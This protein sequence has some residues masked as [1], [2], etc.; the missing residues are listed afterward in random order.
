MDEKNQTPNITFANTR[1]QTLRFGG[2]GVQHSACYRVEYFVHLLYPSEKNEFV[3]WDDFSQY[4][5]K[6]K[7]DP[8]HQPVYPY[9]TD[10]RKIIPSFLLL[11]GLPY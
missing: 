2:A 11:L 3:S 5:Q 6:N 10:G 9:I 1:A 4:M 8:N 7:H